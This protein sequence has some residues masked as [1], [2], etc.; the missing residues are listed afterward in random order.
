MYSH[1]QMVAAVATLC[2]LGKP[3][4]GISTV[5]SH[6]SSRLGAI[7]FFSVPS[8]NTHLSGKEKES[9]LTEPAVC[10]RPTML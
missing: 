9:R 5:A 6:I 8:S 10:S 2:D 1:I 4:I 3:N 7:P